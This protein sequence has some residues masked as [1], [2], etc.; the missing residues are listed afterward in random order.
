MKVIMNDYEPV[1]V[2]TD[3]EDSVAVSMPEYIADRCSAMSELL[4]GCCN[5]PRS[6]RIKIGFMHP[7]EVICPSL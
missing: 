1:R 4:R 3:F 6:Q 7:S 5:W 2:K